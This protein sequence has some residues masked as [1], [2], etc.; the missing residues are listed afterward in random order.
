MAR[1]ELGAEAY[2]QW[3]EIGGV[4]AAGL[5]ISLLP[6]ANALDVSQRIKATMEELKASLPE[7]VE[8]SIP[9]DTTPF[10]EESIHEVYKTLHRGRR[11]RAGGD[12][13][14]SCKTGGPC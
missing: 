12:P 10:V 5:G 7:G 3:C 8:Y 14:S 1:I 9:Y 13:A 4:P 6:G 2:D 11:A